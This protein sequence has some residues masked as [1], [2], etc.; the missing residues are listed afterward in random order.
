MSK[1]KRSGSYGTSGGS[2]Y[3]SYK[4]P[5]YATKT[6]ARP[7]QAIVSERKYFDTELNAS[8]IVA[9]A[10][11][12]ANTELDPAALALFTPSQG[13]DFNN[14]IA[15]KVQVKAIRLRGHVN[16]PAQTNQTVG[17][18]AALFRCILVMDKQTNSAQLNGE[19]VI[20]SGAGSVP[21]D[22][23][24]NPAFF[25]RFRVLKDKRY[26]LSNPNFSWDGTNLE[27]QGM[28][29]KF[30][31]SIKFR[32][33]LYVHFNST[34]GGTVADIIDNSFHLLALTTSADLAPTMSYKCRTTFVDI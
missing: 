8:A 19:D 9:T 10:A 25:G 18:A 17:D 11:S 24:Q 6:Y 32:K 29:F 14:R 7:Y 20:S 27:Q 28:V 16:V 22:M 30:E 13:T 12:W 1:R 4:K 5:K 21:I 31:W 34:N 23:F 3:T 33:P 15:R 26:Q 2:S